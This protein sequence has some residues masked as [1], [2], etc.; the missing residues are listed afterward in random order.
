MI[1]SQENFFNRVKNDKHPFLTGYF[2]GGDP[3]VGSALAYIKQ[4]VANGVDAVEVGIPSENPYL[5]GEVIKRSHARAYSNF[6]KKD[7]ILPFFKRLRLE[8]NVPI[9]VMGYY[10]DVI[11]SGLYIDLSIY[12]IIDGLIIPDL[13]LDEVIGLRKELN[14]FNVSV[15]PVINNGMEDCELEIALKGADLVYCQIHQGKTGTNITNLNELP[16]FYHK[17]R[18]QTEAAL[19]AG[20]GVKNALLAE[21]VWNCGFE[22]VV[23]G[24]EIVRMVEM[25]DKEQFVHFIQGLSSAK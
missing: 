19:M 9:W 16:Q 2:V 11:K 17:I 15:I 3:D 5:E 13:P 8:I 7:Q 22:G 4:A 24:S 20:F 14:K 10:E 6:H 18:S 21:Q 12:Q 1:T 23:V 25:Q